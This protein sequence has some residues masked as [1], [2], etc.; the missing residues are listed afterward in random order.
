MAKT[1]WKLQSYDWRKNQVFFNRFLFLH[2]HKT[3]GTS[4]KMLLSDF[5]QDIKNDVSHQ[6]ASSIIQEIGE[7]KFNEFVTFTVVRNPFDLVVSHYHYEF[8]KVNKEPD[9]TFKEFI[10]SSRFKKVPPQTDYLVHAGKIV[11]KHILRFESL[12]YDVNTFLH[13]HG[14]DKKMS[15][16]MKKFRKTKRVDYKNYYDEETVKEVSEYYKKDLENFGYK[17]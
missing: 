11:C 13:R 6:K 16:N 12:E 4:V 5:S 17:F 2:I 7:E 15:S 14:I 8:E 3:G 9:I 10:M 1:K